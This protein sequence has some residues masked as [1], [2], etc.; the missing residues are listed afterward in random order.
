[1][2]PR[3]IRRKLKPRRTAD[4][5]GCPPGPG[6][7]TLTIRSTTWP[8]TLTKSGPQ[9][10][11]KSPNR[12]SRTGPILVEEDITVEVKGEIRPSLRSRSTSMVDHLQ[13]RFS[14]PA[15][16]TRRVASAKCWSAAKK[17]GGQ[18]QV[19]RRASRHVE[20]PDLTRSTYMAQNLT[21]A[22]CAIQLPRSH[23]GPRLQTANL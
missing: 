19:R 12:R 22:G 21:V 13:F 5:A 1:M 18:A 3:L 16:V 10:C 7:R 17:T 23:A 8:P 15:R 14:R 11:R 2:G 20:G 4:V 6:G 9:H